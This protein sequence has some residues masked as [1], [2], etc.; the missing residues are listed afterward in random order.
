MVTFFEQ[1]TY[2]K[3][4]KP[5]GGSCKFKLILFILG[6]K[7]CADYFVLH[8]C[9][10]VML[11]CGQIIAF[12]ENFVIK[13]TG[14]FFL[15]VLSPPLCSN[16]PTFQSHLEWLAFFRWCLQSQVVSWWNIC[17]HVLHGICITLSRGKS[18]LSD[19]EIRFGSIW[20]ALFLHNS[21]A[22]WNI[23]TV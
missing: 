22:F 4:L 23:Q 13:H 3:H 6:T 5:E 17:I 19:H 11:N 14:F 12:M 2:L 1:G 9:K 20:M 18:L 16:F 8:D 10:M 21:V 7:H 15:F